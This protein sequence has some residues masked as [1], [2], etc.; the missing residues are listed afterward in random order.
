M[1]LKQP[2]STP[3]DL[4]DDPLH[5]A[6]YLL[7]KLARVLVRA[8]DAT[9]ADGGT[10]DNIALRLAINDL[11]VKVWMKAMLSRENVLLIRHRHKRSR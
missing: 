8:E 7:A 5:P 4:T 3:S 1:P 9:S 6:A 10:D 2:R 11:D